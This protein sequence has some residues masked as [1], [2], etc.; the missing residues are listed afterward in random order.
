MSWRLNS[1][2]V[3]SGFFFPL[4][5]GDKLVNSWRSMATFTV[6]SVVDLVNN[7][8]LGFSFW[9]LSIHFPII[10]AFKHLVPVITLRISTGRNLL[11]HSSFEG[12][13]NCILKIIIFWMNSMNAPCPN[14]M[15]LF[16]KTKNYLKTQPVLFFPK[17][18]L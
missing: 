3:C 2:V 15:V 13:S 8:S 4:N 14:D 9:K 6:Y 11:T 5:F 18:W 1:L 17:E 10:D 16:S 7:S 12:K